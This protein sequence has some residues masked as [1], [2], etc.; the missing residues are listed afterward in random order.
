MIRVFR[1]ALI[2]ALLL[3][4]VARADDEGVQF[5]ETRIRPVLVEHCYSCHS[6]KAQE[7]KKLKGQLF[8]DT[9]AGV[10]AGGETGPIV[11]K[12]KSAESP[13]LHALKY[14]GPEMPPAGK[15]SDAIIADFARWIDMGAP[16]PRGGAAPVKAKRVIDIEQGKQ[17]WAFRPLGDPQQIAASSP[18]TARPIDGFL[19]AAQ[20]AHGLK[21]N[22]PT[23]K[24]KLIRRAYFDLIGLPP[25]PEQIA[26]FVDDPSPQA[27]ETVIDELLAKPAYG[28]R[29]ARHWLDA[30]RFAESGGYEFDGFRP[31]AYH[32][33]D[34]VIKALNDDLPFDEFVRMQLA[35]DALHPNDIQAAAATGFLVAG[36]YPGQITAKTV[37]R[38]RYDQLD[39]MMMT[40]GGSMLGLTLGCVRCHDH[41][42]DPIPQQD[43]YALAA[44][45]GRTAHGAKTMDADPAATQRAV[46]EHAKAQTALVEALDAWAAAELP[47]RFGDWAKTDLPKQPDPTRW[48]ILEPIS[49]EAALTYLKE[50]PNHIIATDGPRDLNPPARERAPVK[51]T[52]NDEVFRLS[53][54]TNQKNLQALRF[55]LLTDKSLP[56]RGPGLNGD[57]SFTLYEI[58]LTAKPLDPAATD[59]PLAIPLKA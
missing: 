44:V 42:Y 1:L 38:I 57:G 9:A 45:L 22:H 47:K 14:E 43:Y 21:P 55:D 50:L 25:T 33:R 54:A 18:D 23:S 36:P 56:Q 51:T 26:K 48:Q 24:E 37:E 31:G 46:E 28:E 20:Q 10:A 15:L 11:V 6:G 3:P 8:L 34:W 29:W 41:K 58:A 49:A 12:G 27:F 30:A 40:I 2:L 39:D 4:G 16:D 59:M 17:W 5:F 52:G 7:D 19:R 35:G 13:L 53:F 32:Y